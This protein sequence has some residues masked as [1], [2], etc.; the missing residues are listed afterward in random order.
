MEYKKFTGKDVNEAIVNA[1][2]TLG[3]TSSDLVHQI[4]NSAYFE[5]CDIISL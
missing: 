4:I 1:C 3:I 2:N 5:K